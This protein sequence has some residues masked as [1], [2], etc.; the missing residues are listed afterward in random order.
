MRC[1]VEERGADE[2]ELRRD[3][4]HLPTWRSG[5]ENGAGFPFVGDAGV[6]NTSLLL[7]WDW[8]LDFEK[9]N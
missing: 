3:K 6:V 5:V 4:H 2:T 1:A 9:V 8:I 7:R